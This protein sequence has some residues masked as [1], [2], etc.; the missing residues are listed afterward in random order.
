MNS[1]TRNISKLAISILS[2]IIIVSCTQNK[3]VSNQLK[4]GNWVFELQLSK[5]NP[6]LVLPFNVEVKDKDHLVIK[7][8]SEKI[9]V[10]EINYSKDSISFIMPVF[11]S[12]FKGKISENEIHGHWY[13]YNAGKNYII[14]F[15]AKYGSNE[16]FSST[17]V[18]SYDFSGRWKSYFIS[19]NDTT[20]AVGIFGQSG[21]KVTG[22]FLTDV[23]DYRYLEGIADGE[24]LRLST[25]DGAHAF[26]FEATKNSNGMLNGFF[27]S[28]SSYEAQWLAS[29]DD[30]AELGDMKKLTYLKQ[31]YDKLSFSFPD[32]KGNLISPDD[33]KFNNKVLIVQ[34]FGT[35]CPNCMDETRYLVELHNKFNNQ[36]LEIIGLDFEPKPNMEYFKSRIERF[37]RDLNVPYTLVLAGHSNKQ[38]AAESLPMLNQILSYPTAIFIDKNGD[39][40]E[41]HT[42]FTGPGTGKSYKNYK[43]ET[44]ELIKGMLAE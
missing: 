25:F 27:R 26:L 41:I 12:E 11:G 44:E 5:D 35:W 17:S 9:Q 29:R 38:K 39:I 42:G 18:E 10:S 22:T 37:R 30:S 24:T 7:N 8:A 21:N 19:K 15:L 20:E 16:R 31:G 6:S 1:K 23:G 33:K 32:D 34:I 4:P 13:K 2:L 36:G 14:P 28:G 43:T 3:P 40:R